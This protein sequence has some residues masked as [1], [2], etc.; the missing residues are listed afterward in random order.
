[1]LAEPTADQ[2]HAFDLIG[3]PVPLTLK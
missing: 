1:M 3:A 2:R